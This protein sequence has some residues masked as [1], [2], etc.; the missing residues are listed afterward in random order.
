MTQS[1]DTSRVQRVMDTALPRE[2]AAETG[3]GPHV[4]RSRVACWFPA[5]ISLFVLASWV[6]VSPARAVEL[7]SQTLA[8]FESIQSSY[9]GEGLKAWVNDGSGASLRIGDDQV[10]HFESASGGYLTVVHLDSHGVATLLY[11]TSDDRAARI[12]AG[13]PRSFPPPDAG[14]KLSAEPPLGREVLM[15]VATAEPISRERL[16]VS[17]GPAEIVV[18]EAARAPALAEALR[19]ELAARDPG[20]V[21]VAMIEQTIDGRQGAIEYRSADI[22]QYFTTRTRSVRRPR[23]DFHIHF[24]TASAELDDIARA[25]LDV[26]AQALSDPRLSEMRF[27]LG[28]HTDDVGEEVYNRDLSEERAQNVSHYLVEQKGIDPSRLEVQAHGESS[29]L[30]E[31]AEPEAR[32]LNRRVD[33]TLLR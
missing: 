12:G 10:Y 29:P 14:F 18:F 33:F 3:L 6:A 2:S 19:R 1:I 7:R 9:S 21:Q 23:L 5:L 25:N 24:E 30:E 16:G 8:S 4:S 22:V 15:V 32:R 20:S 17:A 28:G 11:P 31:G 27:A 26:A 13:D